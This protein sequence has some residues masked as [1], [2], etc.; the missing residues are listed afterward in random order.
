[1]FI[2]PADSIQAALDAAIER[3]KEAGVAVPK[4]IVLPDG[5]ITV[6]SVR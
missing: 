5:C 1:M 3:A 2:E 6:P 4:V